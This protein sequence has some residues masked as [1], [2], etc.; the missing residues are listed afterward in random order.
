MLQQPLISIIMAVYNGEKYIEQAMLSV[1]NQTYSNI[2]FII[3]DGGSTDGTVGI[4]KK[5]N[6]RLHYWISEKDSGVYNAWN[7]GL[8]KATGNWIS[9][10]GA[11]DFLYNNTV[12]EDSIKDLN[13]AISNGTRYVYG[14]V[15]LL[16]ASGERVIAVWGDDW[17]TSKKNIFRYM[18]VTHCGAFHHKEMFTE[19][20]VFDETFRI[21]GD[22]EF[23]LREFSK[24]HDALFIDRTIAVMHAGG[25]SANLKSK[26]TVAQ[27]NIKALELNKQ[28]I[29]F[30]HKI[31]IYKARLANF[32]GK[33]IGTKT[34]HKASDFYRTVKGKDKIWS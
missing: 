1:L 14:K 2:E 26:L 12:I 30:H 19:H 25:L 27:E 10:V 7:K 15:N 3:I 32:I 29:T 9:F 5:Y 22:Y 8:A 16:T 17:A 33:Y 31:Q 24:G 18:S 13:H 28:S 4:V 20:G 34:L 23:L 11:D 6:H 21:T